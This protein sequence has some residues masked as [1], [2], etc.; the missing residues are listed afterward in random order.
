MI[1][2][3]LNHASKQST[4]PFVPSPKSTAKG[5]GKGKGKAREIGLRQTT[6]S[7]STEKLKQVQT[8]RLRQM[9]LKAIGKIFLIHRSLY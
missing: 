9:M 6:L 1:T 4:L 5:K 8:S 7:F 3:L 2:A